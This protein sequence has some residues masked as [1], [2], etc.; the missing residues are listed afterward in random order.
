MVVRLADIIRFSKE[1]DNIP[2]PVTKHAEEVIRSIGNKCNTTIG[3]VRIAA[4]G[5]MMASDR[6]GSSM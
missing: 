2:Q 1:D 4:N 6:V 5:T 3:I